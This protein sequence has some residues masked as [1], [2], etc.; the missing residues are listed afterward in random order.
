M[1]KKEL[2]PRR[3]RELKTVSLMIQRYQ[4]ANAPQ[5][6]ERYLQLAEYAKKRLE[7]CYFQERKPACQKCPIH[8]YQPAQ[9]EEI[10][11]VMRWAGPRMLRYAP[12]TT[13]WHLL[14]ELRPAP[15]LRKKHR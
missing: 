9:R 3:R 5:E 8:C 15:P 10:K 11:A 4:Q 12:L 13:L 7:R 2:G 6:N 1:N 14:D